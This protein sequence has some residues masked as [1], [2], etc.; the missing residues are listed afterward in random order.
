MLVVEER[1][2][3]EPDGK[4]A[5]EEE[6]DE[7]VLEVHGNALSLFR[8]LGVASHSSHTPVA[9]ILRFRLHFSQAVRLDST[10]SVSPSWLVPSGMPSKQLSC[11]PTDPH[12]GLVGAPRAHQ[13]SS[14][15]S[16]SQVTTWC[17]QL[18]QVLAAWR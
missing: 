8:F 10:I 16:C 14:E 6:P 2:A 15:E 13:K 4:L 9:E 12:G 1:L 3:D 11:M 18:E 17:L 5:V 7:S